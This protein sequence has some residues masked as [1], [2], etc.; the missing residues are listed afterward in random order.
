MTDA[1]Q[2]LL[3]NGFWGCL[4]LAAALYLPY[5]V[6][7]VGLSRIWAFWKDVWGKWWVTPIKLGCIAFLLWGFSIPLSDQ[8]QDFEQR[9]LSPVYVGGYTPDSA[10][11]IEVY[12]RQIAEHCTGNQFQIIR[13]STRAI[14]ARIGSTPRAIY[15]TALLE[16]GLKW[17]D[18]NPDGPAYGWIQF[19]PTGIRSMEYPDGS[20]VQIEHLATMCQRRSDADCRMMMYLTGAYLAPKAK[21]AP[22]D[23]RL[24]NTIDLYLAV[25]APVGVGK[26]PDFVVYSGLGNPQYYHNAGLDGWYT[27]NGKILRSK[28]ARDGKITIYE[29]WLALES[30]RARLINN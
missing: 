16:C 18:T 4:A 7:M 25:F 13:D 21:R 3:S 22:A 10:G 17:W 6:G 15:E 27:E 28:S 9:C 5:R 20:K 24:L 19:T 8:I 30:K 11:L 26:G 2:I 14:A 12:E 29:I 23:T 1:A